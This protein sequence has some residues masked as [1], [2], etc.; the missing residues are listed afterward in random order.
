MRPTFCPSPDQL[1]PPP[2][3]DPAGPF[4]R[5]DRQPSANL[6][7]LHTELERRPP[8]RQTA[9]IPWILHQTAKSCDLTNRTR[10][11]RTRC[12]RNLGSSWQHVLW[13]NEDNDRLMEQHFP[14]FW[15]MCVPSSAAARPF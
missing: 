10:H 9:T 4:F 5:F 3:F 14:A 15:P 12:E 11:W 13:T 7:A 6:N 1:R 8:R 2:P